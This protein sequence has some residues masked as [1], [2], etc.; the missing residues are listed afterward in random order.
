[1]PHPF[2]SATGF[3]DPRLQMIL[4]RNNHAAAKPPL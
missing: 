2:S 4:I 1:M 3:S